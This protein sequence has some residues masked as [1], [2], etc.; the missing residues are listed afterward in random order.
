M[1]CRARAAIHGVPSGIG[2]RLSTALTAGAALGGIAAWKVYDY[3]P[4]D[5][6]TAGTGL[7]LIIGIGAAFGVFRLTDRTPPLSS[8]GPLLSSCRMC[9]SCGYDI[10]HQRTEPDGCTVCSECGIALRLEPESA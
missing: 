6:A 7:G 1:L 10:R 3:M 4:Q 9:I 5:L 2:L 8:V